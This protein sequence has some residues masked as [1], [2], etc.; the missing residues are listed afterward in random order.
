MAVGRE[1]LAAHY[2]IDSTKG[3]VIGH[4]CELLSLSYPSP[5]SASIG[6]VG[7]PWLR[8]ALGS[9]AT[10]QSRASLTYTFSRKGKGTA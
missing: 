10:R 4:S 7:V 3:I 5:P 2:W 6:D 8:V 1:Q 9:R